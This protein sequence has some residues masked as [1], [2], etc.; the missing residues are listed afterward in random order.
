MVFVSDT[1][2]WMEA[3]VGGSQKP[4]LAFRRWNMR[5]KT[6]TTVDGVGRQRSVGGLRHQTPRDLASDGIKWRRSDVVC[7]LPHNARAKIN[8]SWACRQHHIFCVCKANT[9]AQQLPRLG[10]AFEMQ[11]IH[12][13][14]AHN[15]YVGVFKQGTRQRRR[16]DPSSI[17]MPS[18]IRI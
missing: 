17:R 5:N 7:V 15:L 8:A 14:I 11:S 1:A 6:A 13:L 12:H 10:V 4:S 18:C 16:L 3:V 2:I 9:R